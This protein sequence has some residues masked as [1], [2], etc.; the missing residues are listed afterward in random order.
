MR[1]LNASD[2]RRSLSMADAIAVNQ[3]AFLALHRNT[4]RVP[5]RIILPVPEHDGASLFKP[6]TTP[7]AGGATAMGLKVVS[8]RPAN[9]QRGLPT[10]PATVMLFDHATGFP[11]ALMDGTYLT[12][13]RTAAGSGVAT[14]IAL[15][16]GGRTA[17]AAG[18]L[19]VFGAGLQA[20]LHIRAMRSVLPNLRR[21][22]ICNRSAPRAEALAAKFRGGSAAADGEPAAKRAKADDAFA[23][24]SHRKG[25]EGEATTAL[26]HRATAVDL[27][28]D[29]GEVLELVGLGMVE[30]L[31]LFAHWILAGRL[32][33]NV[34]STE[35]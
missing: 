2:V 6:A 19:A 1:I 32:L 35:S 34:Q 7:A 23:R 18:T 5:S 16:S 13:L 17:A 27:H 31:D 21:V 15:S 12:A 25:R 20:D 4:A 29:L 14:R 9:A 10:V 3:A 22:I 26:D 30:V 11:T 24:S 33:G 28:Q 8:V